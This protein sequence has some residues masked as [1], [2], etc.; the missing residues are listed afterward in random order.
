MTSLNYSLSELMQLGG[1]Q[2]LCAYVPGYELIAKI[3]WC[4]PT[5]AEEGGWQGTSEQWRMTGRI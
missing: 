5:H 1:K 2:L 3:A 4:M